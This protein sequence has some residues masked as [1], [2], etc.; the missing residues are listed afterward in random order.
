MRS[1]PCRV[2]ELLAIYLLG[3][4]TGGEEGVVVVAAVAKAGREWGLFQRVNHRLP[5]EVIRLLQKVGREFFEL[6]QVEKEVYA[7]PVNA[8]SMEGYGTKLHK[9]VEGKK[10][11][12]DHLFHK[13]WPPSAINYNVRL[14]N[15]PSY[16][17]RIL[18]ASFACLLSNIYSK[19]WRLFPTSQIYNDAIQ[20]ALTQI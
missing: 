20:K 14:K 11:W 12:I 19:Y 10:G 7:R 9:E 6:P 1:P 15:P 8:K 5:D 4:D 2:L 18:L 13:V 17:Y 3:S 16:R